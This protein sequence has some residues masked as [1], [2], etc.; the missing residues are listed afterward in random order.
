MAKQHTILIV[1]GDSEACAE[2][3]RVLELNLAAAYT[4]AIAATAA[5]AWAFLR[6]GSPAAILLGG[7]LPDSDGLALLAELVGAYGALAFAII[8]LLD[9]DDQALAAQALKLGAHDYVVKQCDVQPSLGRVIA[10][11]IVQLELRRQ[12]AALQRQLAARNRR[13]GQATIAGQTQTSFSQTVLDSLGAHIAVL[14]RDGVILAVNTAWRRFARQSG[15]DSDEAL[16]R[17]DV[18]VNYLTVCL[19]SAAAG[20]EDAATTYAGIQAVLGGD[21][22]SFTLAYP[23]HGPQQQQWFLMSVTPLD[24]PQGGAV[25]AHTAITVRDLAEDALGQR[26]AQLAGIIDTAMDAIVTVDGNQRIVRWNAAAARM[27]G[28]DA[29]AAIGQPLDRFIPP[30]YRANHSAYLHAFGETGATP[31]AM[32]HQRLLA[33]Q[34]ADGTEFPI[35]ASISRIAVG[36]RLLFTA[37]V[38]DVTDIKRTSATLHET[39]QKLATLVDVLPIGISVLD[40]QGKIIYANP[41]LERI[42]GMSRAQLETGVY[43]ARRYIAADGTPMAQ[44]AFAS[45]RASAEQRLVQNVETGVVDDDGSVAWMNVSAR[46]VALADWNMVVVASDIT[47]RKRA[48]QA[49]RASEERFRAIIENGAEGVVLVGADRQIGYVSPTVTTMLGY[50]TDEFRVIGPQAMTHP[51]DWQAL[52]QLRIKIF[53]APGAT[54]RITVRT[55]HRDGGWRWIERSTIN[56]THN[57]AINSVIVSF[58]D[59]TERVEAEQALRASAGTLQ[60]FVK[61][62]PAAIAMFDNDMRY[63]VASR[64]WSNDYGLGERPLA[65]VSHYDIFPEISE[66]WRAVHRRCLAGATEHR[67][68]DAFPRADG[69]LDWVRWE[70]HPWFTANDVIGGIIMFTEVIT[71][72]KRAEQSLLAS[73]QQLIELSARLVDAQ[74]DERRSLAYELH[75]EIGQQLTGLN[76]ALEIGA[77][78]PVDQ[79]RDKLREAQR[80]VADLTGQV[81]RLSLD[82]RPPMIDELGLLATLRWHIERYR[83]QTGVVVD[84]K[85]SGLDSALP[86]RIA[87]A[88]YR[89]VQEGLTNIAR[90]AQIAAA[91]VRMRTSAGQLMITIEDQGCGFDMAATPLVG[92][93]VGLVGMHERARL[94]GGQLTL[95]S[96]PGEGTR[97]RVTLPLD[98]ATIA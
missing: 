27:F 49:L 41:A 23:C 89:I 48:E 79:M 42:V 38:R 68:E 29:A 77:Q 85:Y 1:D 44:S 67:E 83:R 94:L 40:R 34:R 75:D 62:A 86:P 50:S 14:D 35:E 3:K 80:L 20:D 2:L 90:H 43:R 82:L 61:H 6:T 25:V 10:G 87:I 39:E 5:S 24:T 8:M 32:G 95:D 59:V 54:G 98:A 58:R 15:L 60:L 11:A 46:P 56:Q 96:A 92:R 69:S 91:L 70:V 52:E 12:N 17:A 63:L 31:R 81:R 71:E 53:A 18:G 64:R 78:L 47:D 74:E 72:R 65:G 55:R 97:I 9:A 45:V 28:C 57:P 73:R 36:G 37:I 76:M 93:S 30:R 13:L 16:R 51:D 84:F 88:A 66:E 19:T 4:C 33:A 22:A 7:G 26:E 21:R